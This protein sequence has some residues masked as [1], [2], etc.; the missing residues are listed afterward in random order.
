LACV[1]RGH[2]IALLKRKCGG[3]DRNGAASHAVSEGRKYVFPVIFPVLREKPGCRICKKGVNF[4]CFVTFVSL[5]PCSAGIAA[6]LE[7][8]SPVMARN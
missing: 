4:R 2:E 5:I 1:D 6:S 8:R 7:S 3:G